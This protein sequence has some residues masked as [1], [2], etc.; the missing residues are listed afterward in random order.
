MSHEVIN[1]I[2]QEIETLIEQLNINKKLLKTLSC[3]EKNNEVIQQICSRTKEYIDRFKADIK[4]YN[5][6]YA[7]EMKKI[8][9]PFV[10][11]GSKK[12]KRRRKNTKTHRKKYKKT[13]SK[14]K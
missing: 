10:N 11:G 13:S 6:A 7:I 1:I 12:T 5:D 2:E 14:N 9:D 4:D 8:K 3:N